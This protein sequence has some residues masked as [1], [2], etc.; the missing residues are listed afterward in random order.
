MDRQEHRGRGRGIIVGSLVG[1]GD[2]SGR[3]I[4]VIR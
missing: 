4:V 1:F 3:F 2:Y